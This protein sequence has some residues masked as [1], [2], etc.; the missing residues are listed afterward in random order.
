MGYQ[1]QGKVRYSECNEQGSLSLL[2]MMNYLQ[3]CCTLHSESVGC[4]V[5]KSM[6]EKR[7]WILTSW[8]IE[9]EKMPVLGQEL[10]VETWPYQF[11]RLYGYRNTV[12][13]TTEGELLVKTDSHWVFFD[14]TS[15]RPMRLTEEI[16]GP[17][18]K[19][20]EEKLPMKEVSRKIQ[21]P[22]VYTENVHPYLVKKSDLDTNRHVNNANYIRIAE[23]VLEKSF[24]VKH[25]RVEYNH[26]AL[27]GN[28]IYPM[29]Y[30]EEQRTVVSLQDEQG[31]PYAVV[32]LE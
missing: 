22:D 26:A 8:N 19:D 14:A 21:Q 25:I 4:S 3:D 29:V 24:P 13:K 31:K 2:A 11:D 16:T 9:I 28:Q 15:G 12:I 20:V 30:R 27:L 5:E 32:E 7:G 10:I 17:F 1:F 23:D 18:Q 6:Q